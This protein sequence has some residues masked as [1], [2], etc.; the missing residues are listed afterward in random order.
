M[1][2]NVQVRRVVQIHEQLGE[3]NQKVDE[4]V[5][6]VKNL[7]KEVHELRDLKARVEAHPGMMELIDA[8]GQLRRSLPPTFWHDHKVMDSIVRRWILECQAKESALKQAVALALGGTVVGLQQWPE[9][10]VLIN[11]RS[12]T[13]NYMGVKQ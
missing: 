6:Y 7:R 11:N 10:T 2:E 3:L 12:M 5:E 13:E 8:L 1:T 4:T 9:A